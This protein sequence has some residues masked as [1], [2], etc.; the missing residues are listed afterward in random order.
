MEIAEFFIFFVVLLCFWCFLVL[1]G[2]K[3]NSLRAGAI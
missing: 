2:P 1:F 3:T